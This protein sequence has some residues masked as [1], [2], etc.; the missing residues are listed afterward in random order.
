MGDSVKR[1]PE[2]YEIEIHKGETLYKVKVDWDCK[3]VK[4][5]SWCLWQGKRNKSFYAVRGIRLNTGNVY[6]LHLQ[7]FISGAFP[8]ERVSFLNQNSLDCRREN[9]LINNECVLDLDRKLIDNTNFRDYLA[10]YV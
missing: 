9:L 8:G 10:I 4:M 7:R 1:D 5:F 3:W 2:V 6:Q